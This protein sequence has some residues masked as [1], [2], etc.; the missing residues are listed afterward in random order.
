MI[1]P[2]NMMKLMNAKNKFTNAHP[3]VVAFFQKAL[4]GGVPEGTV[5]EMTLTRPGEEPI[6]TN[7]RVQ[8]SDLELFEEIQNMVR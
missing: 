5:I 2:A 1:N 3:K 6:T 8:Q 7:M 4:A